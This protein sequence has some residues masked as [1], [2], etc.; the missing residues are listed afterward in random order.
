MDRSTTREPD[1]YTI[2]QHAK[3]L[4]YSQRTVENRIAAGSWPARTIKLGGRRLVPRS[5]HERILRE[6]MARAGFGGQEQEEEEEA[7]VLDVRR[8]PGRPRAAARG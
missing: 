1:L 2:G 3:L 7:V 6:A 5:E 4:G 8:G